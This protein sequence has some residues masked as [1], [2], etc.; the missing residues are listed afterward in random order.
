MA[1][2]V[3]CKFEDDSI[4]SEAAIFQTTFSQ[5]CLKKKFSSFKGEMNGLIWP[6]IEHVRDLMAVFIT[7]KLDEALIKHEVAILRTTFSPL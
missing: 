4:K 1:V 2:L 7:C 6:K 5:L 3:T